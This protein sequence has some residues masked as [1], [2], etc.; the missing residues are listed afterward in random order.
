MQVDPYTDPLDHCN[1]HCD[2]DMVCGDDPYC[3]HQYAP[4]CVCDW[5]SGVCAPLEFSSISVEIEVVDEEI[6]LPTHVEV[7]FYNRAH[8][9]VT[10]VLLFL[11]CLILKQMVAFKKRLDAAYADIEEQKGK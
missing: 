6:V 10:C 3:V 2:V 9:V 1:T 4:T 7:Q 11:I 8:E 5:G